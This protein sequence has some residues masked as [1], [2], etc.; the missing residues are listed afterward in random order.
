M[1]THTIHI[2]ENGVTH[3]L[4]DVPDQAAKDIIKWWTPSDEK[5]ALVPEYFSKVFKSP[6]GVLIRALLLRRSGIAAIDV[7]PNP[8]PAQTVAG[9]KAPALPPA[10]APGKVP[11]VGK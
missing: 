1:M 2:I 6:E 10:Q 9:G 11:D 4:L 7:Q 3:R 8:E 5:P